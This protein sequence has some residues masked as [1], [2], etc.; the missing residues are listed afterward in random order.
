MTLHRFA[1][2]NL[3]RMPWKNGGGS[4]REVVCQPPGAGMDAFDWR[5]SIATIAQSGPFSVFAGID[6]TILLLDGDGVQLRAPGHFDHPLDTPAQ[7]FTFSGD[8]AVDCTLRSGAST[9][10]NVM[11]R[12]GVVAAEVQ[13][14]RG[15]CALGASL[16]G[17]VLA[18]DGDWTLQTD[19]TVLDRGAGQGV[20]W[21]D[22]ATAWQGRSASAQARLL[23]V[24][25]R[26]I[27]S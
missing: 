23:T 13:V 5:V 16:G 7:P 19:A 4:T 8:L 14:H 25:I 15:A 12:R 6:R 21:A 20:W 24:R 2:A 27:Q 18:L 22:R 10:F 1:I 3:P 11:T 9:D 17:V 26:P